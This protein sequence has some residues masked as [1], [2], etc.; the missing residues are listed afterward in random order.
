[1]EH[2]EKAKAFLQKKAE[3]VKSNKV[4]ATEYKQKRAAMKERMEARKAKNEESLKQK[5]QE[6][7][8]ETPEQA[9]ARRTKFRERAAA[10]REARNKR[11][12]ERM[13]GTISE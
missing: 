9:E 8:N 4:G 3:E 7:E 1:M 5:I 2:K 6:R 13:S 11:I 10:M 12:K